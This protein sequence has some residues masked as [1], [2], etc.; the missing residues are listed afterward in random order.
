MFEEENLY[1]SNISEI[2]IKKKKKLQNIYKNSSFTSSCT[3]LLKFVFPSQEHQVKVVSI[4]KTLLQIYH[5]HHFV[6]FI[7]P[8]IMYHHILYHPIGPCV[9]WRQYVECQWGVRLAWWRRNIR[10]RQLVRFIS[11]NSMSFIKLL[12]E[13]LG[14][15]AK[16]WWSAWLALPYSRRINTIRQKGSAWRVLSIF[17]YWLFLFTPVDLAVG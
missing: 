17:E 8:C 6:S 13:F 15:I 14:P 1:S 16:F 3:F 10:L 5:K 9:V 2:K 7:P 12:S 4:Y 11:R